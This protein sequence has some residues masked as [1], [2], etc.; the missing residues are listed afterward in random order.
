ML[1]C[2]K[3]YR[4]LHVRITFPNTFKFPTFSIEYHLQLSL[5][6]P[7]AL[8]CYIIKVPSYSSINLFGKY[9]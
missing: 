4:L 2:L 7:F 1:M 5:L 3:S 9:F 6:L 8:I